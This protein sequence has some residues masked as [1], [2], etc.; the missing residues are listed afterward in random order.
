MVPEDLEGTLAEHA[1]AAGAEPARGD[2]GSPQLE[3]L[4]VVREPGAAVRAARVLPAQH[5]TLEG[6]LGQ[7]IGNARARLGVGE[8]GE[9]SELLA[10]A[11]AQRFAELAVEVAEEEE[12]LVAGPFL[13]HED[14]R[15][16]RREQEDGRQQLQL[17]LV[18]E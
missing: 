1:V 2:L 3:Q 13:A 15:R 10:P 12:R 9:A 7:R 17:S 4:P 16:R 18:G 11:V 6:L 5:A 14:E 8:R